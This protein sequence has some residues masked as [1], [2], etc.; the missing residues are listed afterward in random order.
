MESVAEFDGTLLAGVHRI[1]HHFHKVT[2]IHDF[3]R[4]ISCAALARYLSRRTDG[5]SP[6]RFASSAEPRTV[7]MAI[8]LA[9]TSLKP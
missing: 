8:L 1:L 9:W 5:D 6:L 3:E 4:F 2:V 7:A